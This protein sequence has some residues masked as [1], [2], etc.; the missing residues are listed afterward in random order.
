MDKQELFAS[1]YMG[2]SF[3]GANGTAAVQG[4]R[5]RARRRRRRAAAARCEDVDGGL[6]LDPKKRRLSDEQVEMLELS[7]REERKL[8]T[9]RKVHLA[10]ELGLDPK[11]VAVWFQNRRARHK[12][13]LLEEEFAKLKHAHDA[14]ILHKCHL[15]NEVLRLKERLG[16][17]EEEVTRLRSAG[18][19]HA[20][21]GDGAGHH[22][23]PSSSFSTG[24]CHHQQQP[25]FTGG[26]DVML[27]ND[28]LMMYVPDAE[29]GG[30]YADTSVAEWF[31]LYGLM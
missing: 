14:A 17:I 1:S 3:L 6:L 15:E 9:G 21:S 10:A 30:A 16:V 27:G 24:T 18:S 2:T 23:S 26:A 28:D 29:Y 11:Q 8:E 22:G 25:G 7:F 31:S 5:P 19:C 20:T 13:K 12:S 4:E